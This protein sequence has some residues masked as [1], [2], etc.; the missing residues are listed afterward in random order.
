PFAGAE[1][2]PTAPAGAAPGGGEPSPRSTGLGQSAIPSPPSPATNTPANVR[3]TRD[4]VRGSYLRDGGGSD[5]TTRACSTGR[6][7]QNEPSI[8]VDPRA[9]SVV[10]AG[11][12]EYC[13]T[14]AT[15]ETWLGYY[16][17]TDGARTWHDSLVP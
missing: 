5:D 10:V 13:S 7:E 15:G 8:A 16:R 6:R 1:P 4:F 11:A 17:S 12:N 3:V 14:I 9:T 2:F